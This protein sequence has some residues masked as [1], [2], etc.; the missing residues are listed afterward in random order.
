MEKQ[1][2]CNEH[3][4]ECQLLRVLCNPHSL[5]RTEEARFPVTGSVRGRRDRSASVRGA[6]AARPPG[7]LGRRRSRECAHSSAERLWLTAFG[8]ADA[9]R[10]R[11]GERDGREAGED[12]RAEGSGRWEVLKHPVQGP[13]QTQGNSPRR[14]KPREGQTARIARQFQRVVSRVCRER[15]NRE[16][17][18]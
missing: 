13:A 15:G 16:T 18:G 1:K 14:R 9:E 11:Q 17:A 6:P 4:C 2:R 8:K 12:V 5:P 3:L 7:F 10:E